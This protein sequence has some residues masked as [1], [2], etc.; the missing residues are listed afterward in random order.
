M[1]TIE[2]TTPRFSRHRIRILGTVGIAVGLMVAVLGATST[3]KNLDSLTGSIVNSEKAQEKAIKDAEEAKLKAEEELK[4]VEEKARKELEE[5]QK[6]LEE[7]KVRIEEELQ[8]K[9]KD[10]A[11]LSLTKTGPENISAQENLV[12][13]VTIAN[14]GPEDVSQIRFTEPFH[15]ELTFASATVLDNL[16][17]VSCKNIG[18][19]WVCVLDSNTPIAAGESRAIDMAYHTRGANQDPVCD[20]VFV[21][22]PTTAENGTKKPSD[23]MKGNNEAST[24]STRVDCADITAD[25]SVTTEASPSPLMPNEN[26]YYTV[27]VTN[28]GPN[29]ASNTTFKQY[30][31]EKLTFVSAS[32]QNC[33]VDDGAREVTCALG[34]S[35]E[36][37][38]GNLEAGETTRVELEFRVSPEARC[39][40]LTGETHLII[41]SDS[42]AATLDPQ[43]D[44][45][46]TP[47]SAEVACTDPE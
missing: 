6:K 24:V 35:E 17:T 3:F 7:E 1:D 2:P 18:S 29:K 20:K 13:R 34:D 36:H 25:V 28:N 22:G 31:S 14:A 15:D 42:V 37:M 19:D 5:A 16:G 9:L 44:N 10:S 40:M 43:E 21:T 47:V 12:Y 39:E 45:N 26:M 33:T 38:Q 41:E 8:K 30:F 23:P 11:D 4:K 32:I 46:R 27:S